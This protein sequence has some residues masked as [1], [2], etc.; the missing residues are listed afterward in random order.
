MRDLARTSPQDSAPVVGAVARWLSSH[1]E[2]GTIASF[3]A[4]PGEVDLLPLLAMEPG[5]RWVFPKVEGEHLAF[6]EIR[7]PVTELLPGAFGIREPH[8]LTPVIDPRTIEVFLCP[9]LAFDN[10]GGRLGRGRGFYDRAL[11][12]AGPGTHKLGVCFPWQRVD[13]TH[14]EPHDI[15]M[16]EVVHG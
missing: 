6:H 1:P 13:D 10:R 11:V 5:R 9:G 14:P 4:L 16:D 15:P 2:P 3:A 8:H 12:L 7:D